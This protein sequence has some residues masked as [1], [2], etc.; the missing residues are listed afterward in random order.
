M[1]KVEKMQIQAF[2][3]ATESRQQISEPYTFLVN[4]S[5]YTERFAIQYNEDQAPGNGGTELRYNGQLPHDWDF[6]LLIDGTGVV[7]EASALSIS[8]I[9]DVDPV[10]V[11]AEVA[12]LKSVTVD[13]NSDIHRNP[14]LVVSWGTRDVFKGSLTSLDLNYKLFKPDGTPL[15]VIATVKLRGWVTH[16]ERIRNES[17]QSPDIT[18]ERI[19]KASDKF[20]LMSHRIYNDSQY[21]LDV[22]KANGLNSFRRIQVGR[23]LKFP[24]VK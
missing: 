18:H 13:I 19:F 4:P 20:A 22:A 10:D 24:P 2:T 15:R 8:L 12:K 16:E 6:E 5:T 7:K 9:G 3:D 14:Y 17:L 11:T 1:G 21:Y 23:K